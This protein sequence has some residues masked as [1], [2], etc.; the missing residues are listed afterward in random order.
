[1]PHPDERAADVLRN[2][3][4]VFWDFDGVVKDSVEVKSTAFEQLFLGYGLDVAARVRRHHEANGGVS[5]YE[6]LPIYLGWA[7]EQVT[8]G[9]VRFFA[10]RFS[11]L[12]LDAV[13]AAPW[14]PGVREY[15]ETHHSRQHF[16]LVTATPQD[17]IERILHAV[18]LSGTFREVVGAPIAK[19]DAIRSVLERL[20]CPAGDAWMV[21]DT[22]TDL[23]AAAANS[24]PFILRRTSLNTALQREFA[25]PSFEVL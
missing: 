3:A 16:V 15:L 19:A 10:E 13:I 20:G 24:V 12:T 1:V 8:P 4:V 23:R 7:G 6:K 11:E 18:R 17:D 22:A 2:A 14:V 25:G 5:R 9:R 21:G